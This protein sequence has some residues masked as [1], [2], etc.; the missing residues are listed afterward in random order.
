MNQRLYAAEN[1]VQQA[2]SLKKEK[3]ALN[4]EYQMANYKNIKKES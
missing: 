2:E 3:D 4:A 1:G